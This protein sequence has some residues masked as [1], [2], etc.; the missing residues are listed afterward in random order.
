MGIQ[1]F[2]NWELWE[3]LT[4]VSLSIA[5]SM[6]H[7]TFS[8]QREGVGRRHRRGVYYWVGQVVVD[9]EASQETYLAR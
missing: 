3:Q 8:S 4:F 6:T 5:V 2:S 9:A 1:F 7:P